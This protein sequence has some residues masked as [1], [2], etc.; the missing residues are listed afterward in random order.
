M[1]YK[2]ILY[3]SI[4]NQPSQL[5]VTRS[6]R[7]SSNILA[8]KALLYVF[9]WCEV[10][11][12]SPSDDIFLIPLESFFLGDAM[13]QQLDFTLVDNIKMLTHRRQQV[14]IMRYQQNSAFKLVNCLDECLSSLKVKVVGRF[15]KDQ[16]MRFP[17]H[18]ECQAKPAL[19]ASAHRVNLLNW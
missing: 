8:M 12:S 4:Y 7:R 15:V 16:Q 3:T 9:L 11:L 13:L 2:T 18:G 6:P 19:L 17:I 14:L 1:R 5:S 10:C